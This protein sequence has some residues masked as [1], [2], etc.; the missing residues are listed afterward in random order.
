M[1]TSATTASTASTA[2]TNYFTGNST[3]S[4]DLNNQIAHAVAVA[5]LPITELQN[6]Q[7]TITGEQTELQT[8]GSDFTTFQTAVGAVDSAVS[9][10]S[11]AASVDNTSAAS[12]TITTGALAGSYAVDITNL[13]SQTNTISSASVTTAT[14]AVSSADLTAS[15][16]TLTVGS[17][18]YSLTSGSTLASLVTAINGSS[19]G[20]QAS[21][22][23]NQLSIQ[24]A[25]ASTIQLAAAS[26]PTSNL[27]I[28]ATT[29]TGVASVADPTS[30][31]ISTSSTFTL[32]VGGT[33]YALAPA[34]TS[35]DSLVAAINAS[36]ANVQATVVNVG[37]SATPNYEL[38]VQGTQLAATTI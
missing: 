38:S 7:T 5:T 4:A 2:T 16:F 12:A 9:S 17:G 21:V 34:G 27:L 1:A 33:P 31:N 23:N 11:L 24:G 29:S 30:G 36:G 20:V 6:Q 28:D 15:N 13:G 14:G 8:L 32:T 19:A 26:A 22:V 35:L 3:F 37:G 25:S 10:G 18:T